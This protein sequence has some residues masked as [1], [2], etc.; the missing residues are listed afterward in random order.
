MV[1]TGVLLWFVNVYTNTKYTKYIKYI[2]MLYYDYKYK[3]I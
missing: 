2:I 3:Y 1:M